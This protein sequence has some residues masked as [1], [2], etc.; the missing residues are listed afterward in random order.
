MNSSRETSRI[1][2]IYK[3]VTWRNTT[4]VD[5]ATSEIGLGFTSQTGDVIRLCLDLDSAH[6]L[7][8]TLGQELGEGKK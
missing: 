8:E 3:R 7:F 1:P 2:A 5:A 6:D 4:P